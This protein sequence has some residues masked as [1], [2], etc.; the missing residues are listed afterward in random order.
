MELISLNN[1][2]IRKA[3]RLS[4]NEMAVLCDIA[5]LVSNPRYG[6]W[7]VKSKDKMA[8]W[9]D[10]NRDTIFKALKTLELK[11][12]IQRS[13]DG[14]CR[15]TQFIF[16]IMTAQDDIAIL[17]KNNDTELISAKMN[18]IRGQSEK[19]TVKQDIVGKSDPAPS[20]NPTQVLPIVSSKEV[21]T[22]EPQTPPHPQMEN[23]PQNAEIPV[24]PISGGALIEEGRNFA[25]WYDKNLCP[26][27]I[28]N[29]KADL[30]KFAKEYE[31]LRRIDGKTKNEI[32]A[33]VQWARTEE[34]WSK[35]FLSPM[36]LRQKDKQGVMYIDVFLEKV[37]ETEPK[38][39][40][41]KTSGKY[42]PV[43]GEYE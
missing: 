5:Y 24:T 11:G 13:K 42:N 23:N 34:F 19:P 38:V 37:K 15:P 16:D 12:Y 21:Y 30:E 29:T 20:E 6:G 43:T 35:N 32:A 26:K 17:V 33:A 8:E 41:H 39:I 3:L 27:S 22:S 18:E 31:K 2:I 28:K 10:L 7:C 1:H 25:A 36:K 9:L 40:K 4:L 14:W